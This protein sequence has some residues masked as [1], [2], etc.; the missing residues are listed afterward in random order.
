MI[1]QMTFRYTC[2][3]KT[4][5]LLQTVPQH[6]PR[7][8]HGHKDVIIISSDED[9]KKR[10][11]SYHTDSHSMKVSFTC[12]CLS[13]SNLFIKDSSTTAAVKSL[14]IQQDCAPWW[15]KRR[16]QL[17]RRLPFSSGQKCRNIKLAWIPK[18]EHRADYSHA[19][20]VFRT[21]E[22]PQ[23]KPVV[24]R[25]TR[26]KKQLAP[27]EIIRT[28]RLAL[29]LSVE[30]KG[31]LQRWFG[32]ARY[33]YNKALDLVTK[34]G[35]PANYQ[36]LERTILPAT[37]KPRKD[38]KSKKRRYLWYKVNQRTPWLLDHKSC[39]RSIKREAINDFCNAYGQ[40]PLSL[41]SKGQD[42]SSFQMHYRSHNDKKQTI[43]IPICGQSKASGWL[44][45]EGVRLLKR[46]PIGVLEPARKKEYE[47]LR[48]LLAGLMAEEEVQFS[49][50]TFPSTS[51]N[52]KQ[53]PEK[54]PV[55]SEITISYEHGR[56]TAFFL[57]T[58]T[59]SSCSE[60]FSE[61]DL[62]ALD[63]GVRTFQSGFDNSGTFY[64]IGQ[65]SIGEVISYAKKID[66]LQSWMDTCH[67][68]QYDSKQQRIQY[69][70]RRRA[71]RR[72]MQRRMH[73]IQ[74]RMKSAHSEIARNLCSEYHEI[75][76]PRF[77]FFLCQCTHSSFQISNI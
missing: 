29:N 33:C 51:S 60:R 59:A 65:H 15:D 23:P 43:V 64:K 42:P 45:L 63:P 27:N 22:L 73:R 40:A 44:E 46:H 67:K 37:G 17:A 41:Q 31:I 58:T 49:V 69:K 57:Y 55:K 11:C 50:F 5:S 10:R 66:K 32:L 39:P 12:G 48:C 13:I 8:K 1:Q 4:H 20:T 72:E 54:V 25:W 74:N 56:Y 52:S 30:Q 18:E 68:D 36:Q 2:R 7:V 24:H 70:N 71:V 53:I 6:P 3:Q 38:Q 62:I 14:D 19:V 75:L 34:E 61:V 47:K 35:H 76:I 28:Q 9:E 16:Q 26:T 21:H 77:G